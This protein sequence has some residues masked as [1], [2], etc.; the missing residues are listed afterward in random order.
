MFRG[1]IIS[2]LSI[3]PTYPLSTMAIKAKAGLPLGYGTWKTS[4]AGLAPSIAGVFVYRATYYAANQAVRSFVTQE[5]SPT[6]KLLA[7]LGCTAV[8]GLASYPF[9]TMRSRA[10]TA[11]AADDILND[12]VLTS[13]I[14]P[15]QT[16]LSP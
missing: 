3:V 16:N 13:S 10:V 14:H 12:D 2:S 4:F 11:G 9:D 7:G 6:T 15:S 8:A 5:S 1:G